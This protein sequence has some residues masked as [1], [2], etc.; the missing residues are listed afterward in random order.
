[1]AQHREVSPLDDIID[2]RDLLAHIAAL[3]SDREDLE[4]AV[5]DAEEQLDNTLGDGEFNG[6]PLALAKFLLAEWLDDDDGGILL[7]ALI[8]FRD[9]AENA[10]GEALKDGAML[11]RDSYFED[12]A[13]AEAEECCNM[14]NA[15]HWPFNCID[16]EQAAHELQ[17]DYSSCKFDGVTYWVRS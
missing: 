11:V 7:A 2:S 8:V 10:S 13:R 6:E 1:M 3:E 14:S 12:H 17:Y 9:E 16:W 5:S 4:N 15:D